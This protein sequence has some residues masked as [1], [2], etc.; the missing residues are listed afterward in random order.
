MEEI[1]VIFNPAARSE[2]AR[3]FLQRIAH[4]LKEP[5]VGAPA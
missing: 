2:R 5:E 1:L 3:G 4:L